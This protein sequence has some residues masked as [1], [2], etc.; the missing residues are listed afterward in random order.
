MAKKRLGKGMDALF[1][2]AEEAEEQGIGAQ[3]FAVNIRLSEIE[4]NK[5]QPRKSFDEEAISVLA[6]SISKHG[7]LQPILIRPIP[8][9]GYQIVAGERRWRAAKAAG[10]LEI[11]AFIKELGD[12]EA[13]QIALIEN[14]QREDLNP[15]DEAQG[16]ERLMNGFDMTQEQVAESVGKSRSAVANALR[17]LKLDSKTLE[18]V[19]S[20]ELSAGHAKALLSVED[21][22]IRGEIAQKTVSEGLSV[23]QVE[24]LA[25]SLAGGK[26]VSGKLKYDDTY[27]KEIEA[28]LAQT[29]GRKGIS[30]I[31]KSR[32][33][34]QIIIKLPDKEN[35]KRFA[36]LCS[37]FYVEFE[38][39]RKEMLRSLYRR[40]GMDVDEELKGVL[41]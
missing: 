30:V 25:A 21:E 26:K 3:S 15:V 29:F 11:P 7:V 24:R 1:L 12:A 19:R 20:S 28:S 6:D 39:E 31:P 22:K 41:K 18:L 40:F 34:Y 32:G 2:E 17:L 9:G 36:H 23:R 4:P 8:T 10:L 5:N 33:E 16:Y 37:D 27:A 13:A 38:G 14:L 35:L